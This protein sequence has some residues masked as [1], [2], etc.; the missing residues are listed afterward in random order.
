MGRYLFPKVT[1]GIIVLN[2]EPFIRYCLR[3][4]YPFAHEIIVVEGGHEDCKAVCTP[5]GHSVDGTLETLYRFKREEDPEDKVCII[6]RGRFWPKTE[7]TGG[8][9][10]PQCRAY[11]ERATGDYLWQVDIDEFYH[12]D[13]MKA[14]MQ[15]LAEDPS[16]TAVSFGTRKFWGSPRYLV[17]S[18]RKSTFNRIF[19]WAPGYKYVQHEPPRV[20]NKEG[21]DLHA[22]RWIR[23]GELARRDIYLYHYM[24]LF[25]WQVEQK[26]L[27]YKN[28][29]PIECAKIVDWARNNWFRIGNPYHMLNTYKYPSWL[30]HFSG[31]HPREFMRM[32]E[33]I[34][35]GA[36]K[37][38]VRQTDD[39][40][41]ILRSRR[42][43]TGRALLKILRKIFW[44][45][46]DSIK[47][48][49]KGMF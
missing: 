30:E 2:G 3:S 36:L 49:C 25:P 33:D 9:R 28:E 46:D 8:P 31:T 35:S 39:I 4:I 32:M 29:R 44:I 11:A 1:F 21:E 12:H 16:I 24:L 48:F 18:I 6:T 43:S 41:A 22:I 20:H 19:K 15:L 27:I 14:V 45:V 26:V 34:R 38:S 47:F 40:E 23:A 5:D 42:Y 13:D 17:D 7:G 10:T 37:I